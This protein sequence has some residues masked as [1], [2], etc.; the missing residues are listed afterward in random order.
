MGRIMKL[1]VVE[2]I[3]RMCN[4]Q[5][6]ESPYYVQEYYEHDVQGESL[7]DWGVLLTEPLP[8]RRYPAMAYTDE[9]GVGRLVNAEDDATRR[10]WENARYINETRIVMAHIYEEGW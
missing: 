4:L 1:T 10:S 2:D 6:G 9:G 7:E 5:P 3:S 8:A